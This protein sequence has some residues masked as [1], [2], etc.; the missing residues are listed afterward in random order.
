MA[1]INLSGSSDADLVL[2][3]KTGDTSAFGELYDRFADRVHTFAYSRLRD[4]SDAADVLQDTF[5]RAA[6]RIGQLRDPERFRPWLFAIARNSITDVQRD[7]MRADSSDDLNDLLG[8]VATQESELE[9]AEAARLLWDGARGLQQRDQELLELHLREGLEGAELAEAM[10]VE[11]AHVYVM[12]KRLKERLKKS[13]GS[14]L[15]ARSGRQECANLNQILLGWDGS[16]QREIRATVTRHVESCDVCKHRRRALVAWEALA[17]SMPTS[18]APAATKVAVLAAIG[19]SPALAT[20]QRVKVKKP[21]HK[22][23]RRRIKSSTAV[24]LG[25]AATIILAM[26]VITAPQVFVGGG[27]STPTEVAG[28]TQSV[29]LPEVS[30]P[31][32]TTSIPEASTTSTVPPSTVAVPT[33]TATTAV[34][35]VAGTT[36]APTAPTTTSSTAPV[37]ATPT[38]SATPPSTTA[39]PTTVARTTLPPIGARLQVSTTPLQFGP[40]TTASN[41]VISNTGDRNLSF[42]ATVVVANGNAAGLLFT[43]TP[44]SGQVDPGSALT[45]SVA[46]NRSAGS[47][48]DH[49]AQLQI[50]ST[51]GNTFVPISVSIEHPPSLVSSFVTPVTVSDNTGI[52]VGDPARTTT[53]VTVSVSD[54]SGIASVTARWGGSAVL[55]LTRSTTR[56]GEWVGRVG[57]WPPL[58]STSSRPESMT[59]VVTDTRGNTSTFDF[60]VQ[61]VACV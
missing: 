9:T 37:T 58:T 33:T 34:V 27:K 53:A 3:F 5:V 6:S 51:G 17:P 40:G 50:V 52:C 31:P 14:L 18:P 60:G 12:V 48:G 54:E 26:A 45:I 24:V 11:P 21:I 56:A 2:A 20:R 25:S 61:F 59:I 7:R 46:P 1:E 35:A 41:V 32:T 13:I 4:D 15:V 19:I 10:G 39:P 22:S 47:E 55:A 16:Y 43:I 30:L 23:R 36:S 38:P 44:S 8:V 42:D 28:I 29:D 57:P 49:S